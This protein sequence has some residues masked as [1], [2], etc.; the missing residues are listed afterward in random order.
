M[1]RAANKILINDNTTRGN[2]KAIRMEYRTAH[3]LADELHQ[4]EL[5][6]E[7]EEFRDRMQVLCDKHNKADA[8]YLKGLRQLNADMAKAC[9]AKLASQP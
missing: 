3:T 6:K 9:D 1:P 8:D 2:H 7:S 4:L 5:F